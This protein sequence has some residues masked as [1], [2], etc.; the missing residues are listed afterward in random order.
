M[1][2]FKKISSRFTQIFETKSESK[3]LQIDNEVLPIYEKLKKKADNISQSEE[4]PTETISQEQLNPEIRQE[5]VFL[6][7]QQQSQGLIDEELLPF[8]QNLKSK[9]MTENSAA[10]D[11]FSNIS[12]NPEIE[13]FHSQ[14]STSREILNEN[15]DNTTTTSQAALNMEGFGEKYVIENPALDFVIHKIP[16]IKHSK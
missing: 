1:S 16:I 13:I 4:D 14:D 12:E 9:F 7:D 8:Y 5:S 2:F 15:L 11:T 6:N 3:K 10:C